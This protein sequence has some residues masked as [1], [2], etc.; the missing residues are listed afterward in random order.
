MIN[1]ENQESP[2]PKTSR[3]AIISFVLG[4]CSL[5]SLVPFAFLLN[6]ILSYP[7]SSM[8]Y[9]QTVFPYSLLFLIALWMMLP[10]LTIVSATQAKK[11]LV[12][13]TSYRLVAASLVLGYIS[14]LFI[15]SI[16][17]MI[18]ALISGMFGHFS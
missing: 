14:L 15:G 4:S 3:K 17:C 6:L 10:I 11:I 7:F 9:F 18:A 16:F 8:Q 12:D 2:F 5:L 13:Q 1:S